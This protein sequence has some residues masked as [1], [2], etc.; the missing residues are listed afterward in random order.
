MSNPLPCI[1]LHHGVILICNLILAGLVSL[2]TSPF[3]TIIVV[4]A[5]LSGFDLKTELVKNMSHS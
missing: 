5:L 2:I 3:S 4:C 1:K